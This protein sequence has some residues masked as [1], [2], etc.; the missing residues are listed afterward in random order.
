[1]T[2]SNDAKRVQ[3]EKSTK[4][5]RAEK[6]PQFRRSKAYHEAGHAVAAVALSIRVE[7]ISLHPDKSRGTLDWYSGAR[8]T[9]R[10]GEN[11]YGDE[12][13]MILLAGC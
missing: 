6:R 1:M 5:H 4:L 11:M 7:S 13:V 2:N 3:D 10:Q 8:T 9:I 12:G